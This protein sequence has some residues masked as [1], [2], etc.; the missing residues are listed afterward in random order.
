[1]GKKNAFYIKSFCGKALDVKGG[2]CHNEAH[3]IQW[4]YN[5][6]NNQIWIIEQIW[7]MKYYLF[8]FLFVDFYF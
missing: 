1:M 6:G 8:I 3:V 2:E 7:M 4:D 5:G